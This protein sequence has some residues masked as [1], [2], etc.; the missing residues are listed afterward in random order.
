MTPAAGLTIESALR[1]ASATLASAG[2]EAPRRDARLLLA[3]AM[4]VGAEALLAYP[5][6]PLGIDEQTRFDRLIARRISREPVSRI[7]GHREFWSLDFRV[8][9]AV[10]DPRADSEALVE[11]LLEEVPDRTAALRL[12]DLG[13]GSGCLLLALLHEL[14]VASGVGIDASAEA[15]AVAAENA[16]ALGLGQRASFQLGDW[17][18]G[19][20]ER[21]DIVVTN[22]PYIAEA[23]IDA[24]E[25]EVSRF[26]PLQ[27]LAGGQDGLQAYR[28]LAP[29]IAGCLKP[30]GLAGAEHGEGQSEAVQAL[31]SAAGLRFLAVRHDLGGLARCV[32]FRQR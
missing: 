13:T 11:A 30:G 28:V 18:A 6:R 23:A 15:L 29:Q 12:L 1:Q 27:A 31:F 24:L 9:P 5:E 4:Q 8:T 10:L 3:G 32:L 19:L 26:D 7:L 2:V 22:P 17:C 21:F 16:R 20:R 25:P 14:P